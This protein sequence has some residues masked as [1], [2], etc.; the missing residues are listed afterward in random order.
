MKV[1]DLTVNP[2]NP[3]T[4]TDAKLEQLG[5]SMYEHGDISGIVY[6][7]TTRN[8]SGGSQRSKRLDP[9][10]V[11]TLTK[12]YKKPTR[13]GTVA[14]G[15]VELHGERFAYREVKWSKHKEMAANLAANKSA[16]QWDMPEVAKWMKEITSFDADM[17]PELT[18]FD[19][20][21][22]ELLGLDEPIENDP[23]PSE[24]NP[25][26]ADTTPQ[27]IVVIKCKNEM[28]MQTVFEEMSERG[29]ECKLIT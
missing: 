14:E 15:Y 12:Q 10:A 20:N 4:I 3:R 21:E 25:N 16:G 28:D 22:I 17:D 6:N 29:H 19:A 27:F 5:K 23:E 24:R 26:E 18:M 7:R 9:D 2:N 1:R 11:I 13:T 8:L